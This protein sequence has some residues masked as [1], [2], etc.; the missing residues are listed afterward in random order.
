ME[1]VERSVQREQLWLTPAVGSDE[2]ELFWTSQLDR[3][4]NRHFAQLEATD[5]R[6]SGRETIEND[7]E[8]ERVSP[9]ACRELRLGGSA[10]R[11]GPTSSEKVGSFRA[12][13]VA[14]RPR[15]GINCIAMTMEPS[16]AN[17]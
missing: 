8:P 1:I 11:S 10:L 17:K 12:S 2:K 5:R 3:R 4:S 13:D 14:S 9:V 15:P 6:I 16:R 7:H